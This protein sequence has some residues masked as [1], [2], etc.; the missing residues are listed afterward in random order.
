MVWLATQLPGI[1]PFMAPV[2]AVLGASLL[3]ISSN[4]GVYG[5]SRIAYAMAVND[6]MPKFFTHVD[7]QFRTPLL[8]LGHFCAMADRRVVSPRA[9]HERP[10]V[11]WPRCT[12]SAPP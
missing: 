8:A 2:I 12:P 10:A 11:A 6:V 5:S 9:D 7:A 1:G 4:S 3:L